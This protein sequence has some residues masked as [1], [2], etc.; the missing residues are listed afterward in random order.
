MPSQCTFCDEP[1]V[2]KGMCRRH[3]KAAWYQANRE[4]LR[5]RMKSYYAANT[6]AAKRRAREWELAHLDEKR[7]RSR[8]AYAAD[9][10]RRKQYH[11]EWKRTNRVKTAEYS[12]RR[13]AALR[14][15]VWQEVTPD[16]VAQKF[17]YWG[18]RCWMC[19]AAGPL[20]ADHVK[21]VSRGGLHVLANL[22]PACKSC[23]R[24]K[25]ARWPLTELVGAS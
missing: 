8:R 19:G 14:S 5:R 20:E 16:L 25:H 24:S 15:G 22:R 17:A 12:R 2:A 1:A 21:P 23:N 10:S 11:S 7:A 13:R 6:E 9:P 18:N 4:R 3:Y